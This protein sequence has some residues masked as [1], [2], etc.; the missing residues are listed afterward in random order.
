MKKKYCMTIVVGWVLALG[1]AYCEAQELEAALPDGVDQVVQ[2]SEGLQWGPCPPGPLAGEGCQMAVLEGNPKAEQLFTIRVRT[3]EPFV[4]PPHTHPGN[5][6]VTV[7][8]GAL[9]V[10]FGDVVDKAASTRFEVGDYYVNRAGAH[11][12]VWSDDSMTIQLTGI[13][14]WAIHPVD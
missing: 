9:N 7:L 11:H 5:E 1:P 14:P 2:R 10:G 12:F 6:R 13:G 8:E 3:T 4:L